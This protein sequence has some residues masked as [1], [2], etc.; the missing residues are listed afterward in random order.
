MPMPTVMLVVL[1]R[2]GPA[3][4]ESAA[5]AEVF[6]HPYLVE[7]QFFCSPGERQ[8]VLDGQVAGKH[9]ADAAAGRGVI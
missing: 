5:P 3:L 2:T 8:H 4:C 6:D 9:D 7:S 1:A